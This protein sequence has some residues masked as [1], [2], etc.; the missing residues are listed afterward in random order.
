MLDLFFVEV[1]SSLV[2]RLNSTVELVNKM[3]AKLDAKVGSKFGSFLLN[4]SKSGQDLVADFCDSV[5]LVSFSKLEYSPD[6]DQVVATACF[7]LVSCPR[8]LLE[9]S[10]SCG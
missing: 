7:Q 10:R 2:E 9:W 6:Q 4:P 1:L 3:D 8:A 5:S